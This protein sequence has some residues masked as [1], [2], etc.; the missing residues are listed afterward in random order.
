MKA[1]RFREAFIFYFKPGSL[2]TAGP[3]VCDWHLGLTAFAFISS[4]VISRPWDSFLPVL[5]FD[6]V[7]LAHW[8]HL[9]ALWMFFMVLL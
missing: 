5:K 1:S 3:G 9:S 6:L 4:G 2:K 7:S 8:T